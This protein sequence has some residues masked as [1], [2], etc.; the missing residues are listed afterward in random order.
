MTEG[1]NF[2]VRVKLI[3]N[4]TIVSPDQA[5]PQAGRPGGQGKLQVKFRLGVRL[6]RGHL[7]A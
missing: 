4:V 5:L 7:P 3:L 2:R 1:V 6:G